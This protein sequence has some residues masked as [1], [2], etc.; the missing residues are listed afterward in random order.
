MVGP[1]FEVSDEEQAAGVHRR[2]QQRAEHQVVVDANL[3]EKESFNELQVEIHQQILQAQT[4]IEHF[5]KQLEQ[6]KIERQH[7][8]ECKAIR[9]LIS[10]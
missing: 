6:S 5:K 8:E 4:D 10:S 1:T 2:L 3:R 9:K 7:K